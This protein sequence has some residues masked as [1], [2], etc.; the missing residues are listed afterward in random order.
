M[1]MVRISTLVPLSLAVILLSLAA[2]REALIGGE[3]KL[4]GTYLGAAFLLL[5]V[6]LYLVRYELLGELLTDI[7]ERRSRVGIIS[8]E[9]GFIK[10]TALIAIAAIA[11]SSLALLLKYISGGGQ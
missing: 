6:V 9:K 11:V 1:G 10:G 2:M 3:P 4:V 5:G 7:L 8:S